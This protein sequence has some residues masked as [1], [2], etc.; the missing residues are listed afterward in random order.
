MQRLFVE[1]PGSP[2]G[3]PGQNT[4]SCPDENSPHLS[5]V[6]DSAVAAVDIQK[7]TKLTKKVSESNQQAQQVKYPALRVAVPRCHE[8]FG[9]QGNGFFCAAKGLVYHFTRQHPGDV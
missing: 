8:D 5:N 9:K 4:A 3:S 1:P 2:Q 6:A 7:L